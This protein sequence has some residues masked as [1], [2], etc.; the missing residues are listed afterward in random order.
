MFFDEGIVMGEK[1][2]A[3]GGQEVFE[4]QSIDPGCV[5]LFDIIVIVVVVEFIDDADAEG[6]GVGKAAEIDPGDIQ[7]IDKTEVPFCFQDSIHP[8]QSFPYK[9]PVPHVIDGGFPEG[10]L[11]IFIF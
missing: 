3:I 7:V 5:C 4:L 2:N 1:S 8:Y 10:V 11:A 9:V 6:D